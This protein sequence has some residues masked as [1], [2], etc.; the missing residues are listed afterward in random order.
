MKHANFTFKLLLLKQ[1][2]SIKLR[3]IRAKKKKAQCGHIR[4]I[5]S[6]K[7][8]PSTGP[9]SSF[10]CSLTY[11]PP[12]VTT[13]GKLRDLIESQIDVLAPWMRLCSSH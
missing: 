12:L 1:G 10:Q 7:P 8:I 4:I 9:S 3:G 6:E 11:I 2:T 5:R 13:I